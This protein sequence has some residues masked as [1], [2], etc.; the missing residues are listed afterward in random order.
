MNIVFISNHFY[1]HLGGVESHVYN[2][3]LELLRLGHNVTV[4]TTKIKNSKVDEV[5]DG[6]LVKRIEYSGKKIVGLCQMWLNLVKNIK[7]FL[8]ADVIHIHDVFIWYL[9]LRFVLFWKKVYITHHGWEQTYPIPFKNILYKRIGSFLS[10]KTVTVGKYISK[11]YGVK[12][13]LNLYGGLSKHNSPIK[14]KQSKI[15]FLG[16]LSDDTG[17][18]LFLN[19]IENHNKRYDIYFLGEGSLRQVC[20]KYGTVLGWQKDVFKYISDAKI[21]VP[22]GYLSYLDALAVNAKI[23]TFANN[24]LKE[25]Y[26]KEIKLVEKHDT[27]K[28]V[29]DKYLMLWQ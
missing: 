25:D 4:F 26:W 2:I 3:S 11:Y 7:Y 21:V 20:L 24:P 29:A 10:L 6:V 12:S 18:K 17:I 14:K 27:W 28:D 22:S 5:I 16:R 9:P 15:V 1:P 8:A 19:W 13:H 23:I